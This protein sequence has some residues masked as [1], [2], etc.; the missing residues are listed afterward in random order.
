MPNGV[1]VI[2][3]PT[4]PTSHDVVNQVLRSWPGKVGHT[5][6]LD[7]QATGVLPIMVGRATR[8]MRFFSHN[9]KVYEAKIRLGKTT[10]TYDAQGQVLAQAAVPNLNL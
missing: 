9:D 5:G 8:L 6:T 1:L 7:P 10:D 3:K 4:G 2:N